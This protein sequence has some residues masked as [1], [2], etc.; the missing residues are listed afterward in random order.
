M[1]E[2]APEIAG[3]ACVKFIPSKVEGLRN[4]KSVA[5][6]PQKIE[7]ETESEAICFEFQN[8]VKL[9][10]PKRFWRLMQKLG[11]H[12]NFYVGEKYFEYPPH[13][14]FFIFH[15]DPQIKVFMPLDEPENWIKGSYGKSQFMMKRGGYALMDMT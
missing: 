10:R 1:D 8:L 11:L 14:R 9:S 5:I 7:I 12:S 13:K 6:H 3:L 15:T 4:V 2:V